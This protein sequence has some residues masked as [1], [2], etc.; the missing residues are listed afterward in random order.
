MLNFGYER[1]VSGSK[2]SNDPVVFFNELYVDV[3]NLTSCLDEEKRGI[4]ATNGKIAVE[5][6]HRLDSRPTQKFRQVPCYN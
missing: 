5:K 2:I 3:A 6:L 4:E 1:N